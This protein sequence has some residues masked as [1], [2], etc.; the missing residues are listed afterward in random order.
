M[1]LVEEIRAESAQHKAE[2][3]ELKTLNDTQA[4]RI[5]T[6]LTQLGE[7]TNTVAQMQIGRT[8]YEGR[9]TRMQTRVG[10]LQDEV[11]LA[12]RALDDF[13]AQVVTLASEAADEHG[14]CGEIDRILSQLGLEREPIKFTA[15]LQITVNIRGRRSDGNRGIPDEDWVYGC[16]EVSNL[17]QAIRNGFG[18]DSDIEDGRITDIEV[19]VTNAE[20]D[21]N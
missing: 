15:T 1:E 17:K 6:Q 16:L 7:L 14:W 11:T 2:N 18:T 10:E 13:K 5:I 8:E 4:R 12:N 20:E 19:E 9:I 3:A 21:D